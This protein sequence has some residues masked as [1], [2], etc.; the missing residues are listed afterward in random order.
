MVV[1]PAD[2]TNEDSFR[3]RFG[4]SAAFA[5]AIVGLAVSLFLLLLGSGIGLSLT[6]AH[7]PGSTF[8]TLGGIYFLAA[9][10][11]G[12]A[13]GGHLTGRLIGPMAETDRAEEFRAA[14]HGL[15]VWGLCVTATMLLALFLSAGTVGSSLLADQLRLNGGDPGKDTT[16]STYWTD[17][18]FR[19]AG[20]ALHASL[21]WQRFAQADAPT[22]DAQSTDDEGPGDTE[23][24]T[25]VTPMTNVPA[26][27][28]PPQATPAPSP[29][30]DPAPPQQSSTAPHVITIP[31]QAEASQSV[32]ATSAAAS[33]RPTNVEAKAETSH[34]LEVWGRGT[35]PL[36][37][38]DAERIAQLVSQ[39]VGITAADASG[40]VLRMQASVREQRTT[41]ADKARKALRNV[42][43]WLALAW[44]FGALVAT[45]AAISARW[46]DDRITFGWPKRSEPSGA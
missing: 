6:S 24:L 45:M 31:D 4:W 11:L 22:T 30:V 15:A 17:V 13:V 14:A 21:A 23:G 1:A 42:S 3:H 8:L 37:R 38:E 2:A 19:P 18:L 29:G 25:T 33:D 40:R 39:S 10:A 16:N 12:F 41:S 46:E 34:I 28:A 9:E 27:S 35:G 32:T 43:L 20:A 36:P 26:R 44:F 7:A 5:G